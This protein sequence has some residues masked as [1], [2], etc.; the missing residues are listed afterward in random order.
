[1]AIEQV[2]GEP[3]ARGLSSLNE[4]SMEKVRIAAEQPEP[5]PKP[6]PPPPSGEVCENPCALHRGPAGRSLTKLETR[7]QATDTHEGDTHSDRERVNQLQFECMVA[8]WRS[9]GAPMHCGTYRYR[10]DHLIDTYT[11]PLRSR[12]YSGPG[13]RR[14]AWVSPPFTPAPC[15]GIRQACLR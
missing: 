6:K 15:G 9:C 3:F 13:P 1:M 8:L 5:K 10:E 2:E 7:G 4:V 14:R 12:A 11:Y